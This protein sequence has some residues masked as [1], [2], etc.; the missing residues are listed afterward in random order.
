MWSSQD[1]AGGRQSWP[2]DHEQQA[3]PAAATSA[4]R[5]GAASNWGTADR[6]EPRARGQSPRVQPQPAQR[7][8]GQEFRGA[9]LTPGR[10]RQGSGPGATFGS[11]LGFPEGSAG[12][13]SFT[14][15][16]AGSKAGTPRGRRREGGVPAQSFADRENLP[17]PVSVRLLLCGRGCERDLR[18][19]PL[20][21][22]PPAS[23]RGEESVV[24]VRSRGR[25]GCTPRPPSHLRLL[26]A[27]VPRRTACVGREGTGEGWEGTW[28]TDGAN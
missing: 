12:E 7:L 18:V 8:G 3:A 9:R 4:A 13:L 26:V 17:E 15:K 20:G 27:W 5:H 10:R 23:F 24:C 1:G 14:A 2:A 6:R 19:Q 28:K 11:R 21:N 16:G 25:G 22:P